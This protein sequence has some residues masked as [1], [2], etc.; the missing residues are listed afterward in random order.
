M[1]HPSKGSWLYVVIGILIALVLGLAGFIVMEK[2]WV[3]QLN[4]GNGTTVDTPN[5][6]DV[7]ITVYTDKRCTTCST[8]EII[9][10]MQQIPFLIG[11]KFETK[12]FSDAGVSE[13]L[14][15]NNINALPAFVFNT[16]EFSDPQFTQLLMP[17]EEGAYIINSQV[18]GASF[19]PFAKRS[20]KWLLVLEKTVLDEIKKDSFIKG[21]VNARITWLE[22]SDLECPY[23]VKL[24]NSG[25]IEEIESKYGNALNRIFNHF[26]LDFHANAKPA[27]LITECLAQQKWSEA[28]YALIHTSFKDETS[29]KSFL[30]DEAVKLGADKANLE[31]CVD[32]KTFEAKIDAQTQRGQKTFGVSGTPGSILINNETGEYEFISGAYPTASFVEAIDKLLK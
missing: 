31:K 2:M 23:C 6:K 26:P 9:T 18:T 28:F 21:D 17:I 14:Q 30:I 8:Q 15:K 10:Q 11:A 32:D 13:Y 1:T 7:N 3:I 29:T 12:D 16:N 25:T 22:Y 19:D 27:A 4:P 24:H 20:E 5:A